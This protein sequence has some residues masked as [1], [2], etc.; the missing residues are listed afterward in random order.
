MDGSKKVIPIS[1]IREIIAQRVFKSYHEI[2]HVTLSLEVD[3]KRIMDLRDG[4]TKRN[5]ENFSFTDIII[6]ASSHALKSHPLLNAHFQSGNIILKEEI[7]IGIAVDTDQGII[8]PVIRNLEKMEFKEL[9]RTRKSLVDKV[10]KRRIIPD[11]LNGGTF[12][13][14]NLGNY[15]INTFNPII[16]SP[17][18]AILGVGQIKDE[19]VV[20]NNNVVVRPI[21]RLCLSFDHRVMDGVPAARFLC[22]VKELLEEPSK[23]L[24]FP[25]F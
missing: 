15:G 10:R 20:I 23:F 21:L 3:V 18:V 1:G 9:V 13:I 16:N 22:T 11:E 4:N 17:E 6:F 19:P 7:N 8:V 5:L 24:K 2:P 14:T 12:T 25:L